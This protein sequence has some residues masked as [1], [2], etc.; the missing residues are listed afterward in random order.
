MAERGNKNQKY[1]SSYFRM[2]FFR[3][4]WCLAEIH[5]PVLFKL[6][7]KLIFWKNWCWR[8]VSYTGI[9]F[10]HCFYCRIKR[11]VV[12][13]VARLL[14]LVTHV[15]IFN[16]SRLVVKT[17]LVCCEVT[18]LSVALGNSFICLDV[19]FLL[20]MVTRKVTVIVGKRRCRLKFTQFFFNY[21]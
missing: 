1:F 17:A 8:V 10:I 2:A 16:F 4:C 21:L 3:H 12:I 7:P 5:Q 20:T 18:S 13:L 15:S 11:K 9:V 19:V 6:N 14:V